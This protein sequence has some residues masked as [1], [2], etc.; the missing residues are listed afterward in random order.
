MSA[1]I[2][3]Y[4]SWQ[5]PPAFKK[6]GASPQI[7][8]GDACID[9]SIYII[10]STQLGERLLDDT[11]GSNLD[12]YLFENLDQMILGDIREDI[13][14]AIESHEPR[15]ILEDIQ[16]DT[17]DIYHDTLNINITYQVEGSENLRT[18]QYP[19][20]LQQG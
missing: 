18:M 4:T 16:F 5:F 13:A 14:N 15:V 19:L 17:S 7:V 10:L 8:Q 6:P 2:K 1:E 11:F 12:T 3:P 20:A 9:Q